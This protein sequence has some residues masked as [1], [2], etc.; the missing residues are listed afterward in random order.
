[1]KRPLATSFSPTSLAAL[2]LLAGAAVRDAVRADPEAALAAHQV[3]W[4][5][6]NGERVVAC[7]TNPVCRVTDPKHGDRGGPGGAFR[8]LACGC[9]TESTERTVFDAGAAI[10]A[11]RPQA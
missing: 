1:M 3:R 11:R 6:G 10:Q 9:A 5:D 2:L 7:A 4:R 8:V